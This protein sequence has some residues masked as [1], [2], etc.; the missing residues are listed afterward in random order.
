VT[1]GLPPTTSIRQ[2][3]THRLIPSQY[4]TVSVLAEIADDDTHLA[5]IQDLDNATNDRLLAQAGLLPGISATELVSNVDYADVIN[6]AFTHVDPRGSRFN[7]PDRG[8]WYA[9]FELKTAQ[10]EVAF[11]T[12]M[13][14]A[15]IDR[16]VE[17]VT[18]DVY[19]ADLAGAYHDLR[20][21]SEEFTPFLDPKRYRPSQG[22]AARLLTNTALGIVYPSVRN[23]PDGT[24]I[25]CFRPAAISHVRRVQTYRFQ[26]SGNPIPTISP[27]P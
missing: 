13:Q 24:C 15:D 2:L 11:H 10:T 20:G 14:L 27:V 23:T 5:E 19:L 7:A 6:A 26:W 25:A 22:L 18:Y 12:T 4:S 21:G 8:A 1:E 9:A 3:D 16:F 17:D